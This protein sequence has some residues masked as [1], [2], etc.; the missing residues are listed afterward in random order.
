MRLNQFAIAVSALALAACA[1]GPDYAPPATPAGAAGQFVAASSDAVQPLA[2]VPSDWWRLYDDPVL[3]G[4]IAD[5]LA[6]N[7]DVRAAVAR[8]ARARAA[9]REVK[10]D[11]LPQIDADASVTRGRE[12]GTTDSTTSFDGRLD[13]ERKPQL[14]VTAQ[15]VLNLRCQRCLG[16]IAWPLDLDVVLQPVRAGQPI[17]D[18]ELENDEFDAIEVRDGLDV[19]GMVEDEI[20]LALPIAP[21]HENCDS[22]RPE[23][24]TVKESPFARL[25]ALRG[26]KG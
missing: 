12:T 8:L 9:L 18:E 3:D 14:R 13:V 1:A 23:G 7:T 25:A 11:R 24:G 22:L 19:V 2:P 21:R 4:L 6:A 26:T 17:P 5:A 10:I 16:A 15:G 20:L